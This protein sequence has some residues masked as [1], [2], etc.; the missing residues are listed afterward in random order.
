MRLATGTTMRGI[1]QQAIGG[2]GLPGAALMESAGRG[3]TEFLVSQVKNLP[4]K[5][6]VIL[7][8]KGNNGG[9]GFV[10][11]RHLFNL[12][13]KPKV[14]LL[15]RRRDLTGD[16]ATMA[17]VWAQMGE[18]TEAPTPALWKKRS[19]CLNGAQ[20]V[21]DGLLGTGAA[22]SPRGVIRSA[23]EAMNTARIRRGFVFAL[24]APSGLNTDDGTVPGL[25]VQAHATATFG[26]GKVGLFSYPGAEYA[27][28]VQ[29]V[30]IGL[31]L[32]LL[33]SLPHRLAEQS[34]VGEFLAPLPKNTHKGKRGRVLVVAGAEEKPGAAALAA[35]GAL[36]AGA[37]LVTIATPA[38]AEAAVLAMIPEAM[39]SLLP[40]KNGVVSS[41]AVESVL[42]LAKKANAVVVGPGLGTGKGAQAVVHALLTDV[43]VPLVVD[44]DALNVCAR[45]RGLGEP[46]SRD[47]KRTQIWKALC[48]RSAPTILTPHPGECGRLMGQ[49]NNEINARRLPVAIQLAKETGT[50]VILKGARTVT[51]GADGGVVINPTAHGGLATGGS[52]D[53]LAG[54]VGALATGRIEAFE[55][56]WLGAYLHGRAGE[57]AAQELGPR[58]FLARDVADHLPHAWKAVT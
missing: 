9:D 28:R 16:A 26:A 56:A 2:W 1:D 44:A 37:G 58:G 8:G 5:K 12:G 30:D 36:R 19:G 31:P 33:E 3:A 52:G 46:S 25:C 51:A 43:A 39:A 6:I 40:D 41:E 10:V 45:S 35:T 57:F 18:I 38:S 34:D 48:K 23:I 24:D 15:A 42:K 47:K 14:V 4:R 21:I 7:C 27:G 11:A 32:P 17:G 13:A 29:V 53:V 22:G 20:V 49:T 50:T 54:V 55:A